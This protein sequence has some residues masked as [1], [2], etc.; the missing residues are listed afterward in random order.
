VTGSDGLDRGPKWRRAPER[1][2]V[3]P[4]NVHVWR[5]D[6]DSNRQPI[7]TVEAV[8]CEEERARAARFVYS[9]HH[10][11]FAICRA[12]LR[13]ILGR[14][15]NTRPTDLRFVTGPHGKPALA[16]AGSSSG[17]RFSVSHSDRLALV[18]IAHRREVGVDIERIRPDLHM[19]DIARRFFGSADAQTL[20]SLPP[21]DLPAEFF[22]CWCS[23]EACVKALSVGLAGL[24]DVRDNVTPPEGW[25]ATSRAS[26]WA[27]GFGR[28]AVSD[29]DIDAGFAASL[30]VEGRGCLLAA[31]SYQSTDMSEVA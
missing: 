1:P 16:G 27:D 31:F 22:R 3:S 30:A 4:D 23:Q 24:Q 28:W 14:Y 9:R 29:L 26:G 13:T 12:S 20:L 7:S 25:L 15:L 10:R 6:L 8:L 21:E 2:T 11:R 18:A 19:Q 5:I 17:I